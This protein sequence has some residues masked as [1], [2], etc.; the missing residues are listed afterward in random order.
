MSFSSDGELRVHVEGEAIP[1][2]VYT[3]PPRSAYRPLSMPRS[4]Q[5]IWATDLDYT[6]ENDLNL[7]L[8]MPFCRY[9]CGFCNLYTITS[10]SHSL[11][12]AYVD[13]VCQELSA[14]ADVLQAR[15]IRT[16]YFG[17]GT[18]SLLDVRHFERIIRTLDRLHVDL[19]GV[20][21][22]CMEASPDS[23]S[24][25]DGY[26]FLKDLVAM[27]LNRINLGIESLDG[28]ELKHAGR[29]LAGVT[30]IRGA[31]D[32][33]REARVRNLSVDLI[34]GFLGQTD[35]SWL[36]S[37]RGVLAFSPETISTYMLTIR[38][39]AWFSRTGRYSYRRDPALYSRYD[40]AREL[41]L[42]AGYRQESNVRFRTENG[43][44]LQKRLQFSGVPVLGVGLGARTYTNTVDYLR[45]IP[46]HP[47]AR[48][49]QRYLGARGG[50]I[51]VDY[52]FVYDDAERIRKRL[53]LDMFRLDV[54]RLLEQ[55]E[56]NL[57]RECEVV[58]AEAVDLG[59]A[60][61]DDGVVTLSSSGFKYR[62]I[63]SWQLFSDLVRRRD[64]E[65]YDDPKLLRPGGP[66]MR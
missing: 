23:L 29:N 46:L 43:G 12:D 5:A 42:S 15:K 13:A 48:A 47:S 51:V 57:R 3:Y 7:Y 61:R 19:S 54:R 36:S 24:G 4:A 65:F 11:Y 52:G 55:A 16:V 53:V 20:E 38:P 6:P 40:A 22:F 35:E 30:V 37:V 27:G 41:I 49:M 66:S 8:H 9:K 39:D 59:L 31:I 21:E 14:Y 64:A 10:T 2:F 56:P 25:S 34:M 44:Y 28:G 45:N 26:S 63:I 62:D 58:L 32:S 1:P 60:T 50:D 17:G 33:V 18:P